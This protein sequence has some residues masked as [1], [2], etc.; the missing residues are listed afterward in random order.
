MKVTNTTIIPAE[1][2]C[3][4]STETE[5]FYVRAGEDWILVHN[6]PAII[7]GTDPADG[8]FFVAK[9]SIFNKNPKVYKTPTDV[10]AD[11][12]GDL[13]KK[14]LLALKELPALGI[15]GII[16]G[17]FMYDRSDLKKETIDGED[18]IVFHPNTLAYAVPANSELGKRIM[19][20][21]LGIVWHTTYVGS[22]FETLRPVFDFDLNSIKQVPAVWS[23]EA[24]VRDLSGRATLTGPESKVLHLKVNQLKKILA[25]VP[26]STHAALAANAPIAQSLE[27]YANSLIRQG[28]TIGNPA[29]HVQ[30]Y[31]AWSRAKYKAD[32][33]SKKSPA[34]K[35]TAT[36]KLDLFDEFWSPAMVSAVTK[37]ISGQALVIELKL[38]ILNQ[39]EKLKTI[40]TFAKTTK[41]FRVTKDEGYV[42][43]DHTTGGALKIVDR[44]EF[45]KL[46][47][48]VG[49][50]DGAAV[51]KGW[52]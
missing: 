19:S 29:G 46:N 39:F 10:K 27:T 7:C 9:K 16:Q 8:K 24:A 45:S 6:S 48:G 34:G 14:L 33:D 20:S 21:K 51:I 4:I 50:E 43:V 28:R 37:L 26:N 38:A 30:D 40:K 18:M 15:K 11:T 23:I 52:A 5:N 12:S 47:F 2:H 22:S 13:Q 17:D 31:L 32:I 41:G 44:L 25:S 42:I 1:V 35:V 3:D 49:M 36:A